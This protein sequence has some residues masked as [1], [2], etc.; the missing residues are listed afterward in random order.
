[1]EGTDSSIYLEEQIGNWFSWEDVTDNEL[2][3]D[4]VTRLLQQILKT[5]YYI[6][7]L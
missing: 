3:N 2:R 5:T 4:V 1:M 7:V 6:R